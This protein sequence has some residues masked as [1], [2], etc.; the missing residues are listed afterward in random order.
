MFTTIL[1]VCYYPFC[2]SIHSELQKT[3]LE[4]T[5]AVTA[6]KGF[7]EI[8]LKLY[9]IYAHGAN[10]GKPMCSSGLQWAEL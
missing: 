3:M 5:S 2:L 1:N 10:L 6:A 9:S 8:G 4:A 7:S